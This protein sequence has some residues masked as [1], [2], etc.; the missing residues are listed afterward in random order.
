MKYEIVIKADTN[1]A[2]YITETSDITEKQ[3]ERIKPIIKEIKTGGK[4]ERYGHNFP[5]GEYQGAHVRELYE[6]VNQKD[7]DFF[8]DLCPYGE[9]GIHTIE[10]IYLY[11]KPT[12]KKLL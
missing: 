6:H 11:P 7:L 8:I 4:R 2:D 10:S 5:N 12:K 3:L 1:D 9:Y